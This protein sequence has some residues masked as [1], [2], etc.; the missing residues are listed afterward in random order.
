M[1]DLWRHNIT[2]LAGLKFL[3]VNFLPGDHRL[4][5]APITANVKPSSHQKL[6]KISKLSFL[7]HKNGHSKANK[8]TKTWIMK[9]NYHFNEGVHSDIKVNI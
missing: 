1:S 4:S 2:L 7:V 9:N 3:E 5:N 6:L 8:Y